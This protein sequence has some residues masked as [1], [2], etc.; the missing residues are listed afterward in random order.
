MLGEG[1]WTKVRSTFAEMPQGTEI[2]FCAGEPSEFSE[3]LR[4]FIRDL[5]DSS[6]GKIAWAEG[7]PNEELPVRPCFRICHGG[8]TSIAYAAVPA[9]HQLEPFLLALRLISGGAAPSPE[10]DPT[11]EPINAPAE[12]WVLVSAFCPR[13]PAVVEAVAMLGARSPLLRICIIDAQH[14]A[15]LA[16]EYGIKSVPAT[17]IDRRLVRTGLLSA[18]QLAALLLMRGTDRYDREMLRSLI[19]RGR[20]AEAAKMISCG[21]GREAVLAMMQEAEFSTRVGAL[22]VLENALER[23]EAVVR[24]MVPALVELLS[25]QDARVRGDVADFLGKVGDAR[26]I[27]ELERLTGDPDPDVVE[28]AT[29]ALQSIRPREI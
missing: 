21:Q 16:N 15:D 11:I 24:E 19:E 3:Q 28:A 12:I 2:V 23:D 5:C 4:S 29:E 13:C 7:N 9:G 8:R 14:F 1:E 26:A 27:P 18:R 10:E 25:H 6:G 17:V 22:T 20:A